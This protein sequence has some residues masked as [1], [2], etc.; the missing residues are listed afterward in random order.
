MMKKHS[1]THA[2]LFLLSMSA[3]APMAM[4]QSDQTLAQA[5]P[6]KHLDLDIPSATEIDLNVYTPEMLDAKMF[7]PGGRKGLSEHIHQHL[8]YPTIAREYGI[9]GQVHV[10]F[11]INKLGKAISPQIIKGLGA[12]C[13]QEV[14]RLIESMPN[15]R[16]GIRGVSPVMTKVQLGIDFSLNP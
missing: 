9:E 6:N 3:L 8:K 15:W 4:A 14:I 13:D 11:I 7:F 1:W 16:P 12:G 10:E 2:V 5:I